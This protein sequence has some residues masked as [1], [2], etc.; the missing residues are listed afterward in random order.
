VARLHE[1]RTGEVRLERLRGE[2]GLG[3]LFIT[4]DLALIRTIADRVDVMT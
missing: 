3:L 4:H 1:G 2:I